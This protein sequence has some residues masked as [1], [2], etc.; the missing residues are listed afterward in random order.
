MNRANSG[1]GA[2]LENIKRAALV[3]AR[4][5]KAIDAL[6]VDEAHD[7][8]IAGPAKKDRAISKKNAK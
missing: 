5:D 7:H 4:R 2:E 1:S 8:V 6:D 3:A